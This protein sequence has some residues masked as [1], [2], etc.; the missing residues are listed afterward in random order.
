M[1]VYYN[2][3]ELKKPFGAVKKN[4][5][6]LIQIKT[7]EKCKI[8]LIIINI[9]QYENYPMEMNNEFIHSIK[10][11]TKNYESI[12]FY[13]FKIEQ[14]RNVFYYSNNSELLGGI[15]Q[16][17]EDIPS[18]FYQI[19]I[20]EDKYIPPKWYSEGC[21][22]HIFIDRFYNPHFNLEFINDD[23]TSIAGGNLKGIIDK[24]D[25][26]Q[27]LG[28]SI[29]LL[30]PIFQADSYHR[31]HITD[32]E[33]VEE[34]LGGE[35]AFKLLIKELKKRNMRIILDG[36][37]NHCCDNSKYFNAFFN[38]ETIGAY[39][40]KESPY[41]G[42]FIFNEYPDDY[43]TFEDIK[44]LP[45][46]NTENESYL[47]YFL[48]NDNSIF[49]KWSNYGID[50]WRLDAV[51]YMKNDFIKKF[52][53]K[54]KNY[55]ENMV[56]L[57]ELWFDASNFGYYI[58][59]SL[60]DYEKE[61]VSSN[62]DNNSFDFEK[63]KYKQN[64]FFSGYQ[65]DSVTNYLLYNMIVKYLNHDYTCEIFKNKYYSLLENYPKQYLYSTM[66][67]TGTHDITRI[68]TVLKNNKNLLKL[69]LVL[70]FSLPG[71]PTIYYGDEIGL[72]GNNDPD[73]RKA[74]PW[75]SYDEDLLNFTKKLS[76]IRNKYNAFKKGDIKFIDHE[77]LLIIERRYN[78]EIFY[79]ILNN[80]E[81]NIEIELDLAIEDLFNEEV[82]LEIE[83]NNFKIFKVIKNDIR[84]L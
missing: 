59:N 33:K 28:I 56:V 80:T 31:Y 50:G 32:F 69:K 46:F 58:E 55:D 30:T 12:I 52:Y 24:L 15:G 77:K 18:K 76:D 54:V 8:T 41:Y 13:F 73:N 47:D 21:I 27:S 66:N 51:N 1:K 57:I 4:D 22:Y 39:Q 79:I 43:E 3:Y 63:F 49:K 2:S 53:T 81:E 71:V 70:I 40:S 23:L 16:I 45:K 65:T 29:I 75:D 64:N 14:G 83:N 72:P 35:D 84:V 82:S 26:I 37:F 6:V 36:V 68:I 25:Y 74:Y 11:N 7:D 9:G 5:E 60:S 17:Y 78:E 42:W 19:T 48:R 44:E 62:K 67:F 38:F 10:F 34:E 61:L 20:Y